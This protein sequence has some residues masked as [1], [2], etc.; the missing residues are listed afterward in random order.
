MWGSRPRGDTS[1]RAGP[2]GVR[3]ERSGD[4]GAFLRSCHVIPAGVWFF[5][6]FNDLRT[7]SFI[8]FIVDFGYNNTFYYAGMRGAGGRPGTGPGRFEGGSRGG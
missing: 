8:T 7:L 4:D 5:F 2:P 3:G 1:V 6:F